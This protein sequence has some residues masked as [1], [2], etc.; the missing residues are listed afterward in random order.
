MLLIHGARSLLNAAKRKDRP[1]RLRQWAL[2][3]EGRS[4]HNI[5]AVALANKLARIAW[6]VW[7]RDT[8]FEDY[9]IT[10]AA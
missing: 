1:G 6:A 3:I 8:G 2:D 10:K 4:G 5:A 7:C 9:A